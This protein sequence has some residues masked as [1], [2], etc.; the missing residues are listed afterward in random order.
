[1]VYMLIRDVLSMEIP[2][3][4]I[5]KSLEAIKKLKVEELKNILRYRGQPMTGKKADLVLPCHIHFERQKMPHN[6]LPVQENVPLF[7]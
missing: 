1:M 3:T 5:N 4:S 6:I 2:I 7:R